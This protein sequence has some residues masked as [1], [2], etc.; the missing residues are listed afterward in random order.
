MNAKELLTQHSQQFEKSIQN[1]AEDI[2]IAIGYAASNVA[3]IQTT[4]GLVVVDTTESTKAAENILT[5]FRKINSDPIHTIIYTH[6]HRDHVCGAS[7]FAKDGTPEIYARANLSNELSQT[8]ER[9]NLN[10]ILKKRAAR[11][12]GIPLQPGSELINLGIG[13]ADRPTDGMG[14]G[15]LPPTQQVSNEGATL[16]IGD[17]TLALLAAPGETEDQ[18]MIWLADKKVLF[19]ADNFYHSFPNLYAIRGTVFRDFETW[20][21]TL[22]VMASLNAEV[23]LLGHGQPVIGASEIKQRLTDYREAILHI[24]ETS[25]EGM[26]AGLT[27]DELADYVKLPQVLASK[28]YLQEFYGTVIW[29]VRAFYAGKLGWFDGNPTNLF[30]LSEEEQARRICELA[31]D[32]KLYED[33]T[34]AM[35]NQDYQWALHLTDW[36]KHSIFSMQAIEV[37]VEALRAI[38]D[39]QVNAT[40]RNYYLTS[41]LELESTLRG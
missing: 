35:E 14:E 5:D 9:S 10:A 13:P 37:R 15:F 8:A 32:K 28:P 24:V 21:N 41:A 34:I 23:M 25:A 11:Q 38:A 1:P 12:F 17:K 30:P 40:A 3:F 33:L 2:W 6:G 19:A 16:S 31:G 27:P 7:V 18:L 26:N 20:A 39:Q 4:Q 29:S 36:L 22:K